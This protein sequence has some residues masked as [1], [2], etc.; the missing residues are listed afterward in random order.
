MSSKNVI[1]ASSAQFIGYSADKNL[2]TTHV[3]HNFTGHGTIRF[4][5][6]DS[7]EGSFANGKRDG[8]GKYWFKSGGY[9]EGHYNQ[10][11]RSGIGILKLFENS[12]YA[13]N[14]LFGQ[15]YGKG[16]QKYTNGDT[17]F[18]EWKDG[19]RHGEGVYI[20]SCGYEQLVGQWNA[21]D[22]SEGKWV[23]NDAMQYIGKFK[24][25]EPHGEG[26]WTFGN[27]AVIGRSPR[28]NTF[29]GRPHERESYY[30]I[31]ALK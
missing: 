21:G 30:E 4:L 14:F 3:L 5:N 8:N 1:P 26:K 20:F 15:K 11:Q 18:G 27:G 6:G 7:Y 22:F 29:L 28:E 31:E 13:G 25:N 19:K 24:F 9:Y 2:G 23:I 10:G 16:T 12:F 17:Y